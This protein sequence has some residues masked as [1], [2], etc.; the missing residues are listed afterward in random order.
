MSIDPHIVTARAPALR[1]AAVVGLPKAPPVPAEAFRGQRYA[2][3]TYRP[4]PVRSPSF[5]APSRW[6]ALL[7]AADRAVAEPEEIGRRIDP[8]AVAALT[9]AL[10]WMF[11]P[12][13]VLGHVARR[14][15]RVSGDGG[16]GLAVLA[17]LLG[18]AVLVL[19]VVAVVVTE[20]PGGVVGG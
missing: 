14:R 9:T 3:P 5:R 1:E 18:Y 17:L 7:D 11:L 2:A 8:F 6:R 10:L 20:M 12:A 13:I 19:A 4:E 16:D 15:V